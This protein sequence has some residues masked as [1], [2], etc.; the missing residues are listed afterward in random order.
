MHHDS[1]S[2]DGSFVPGI[3]GNAPKAEAAPLEAAVHQ[4]TVNS[5]F[6]G[7]R[8]EQDLRNAGIDT[9]AIVG[10][11]T[12]HCVSKTTRM[13][14]LGFQAYVVA[15]A[16]TTFDQTGIDGRRERLWMFTS[17]HSATERRVSTV[18][19]TKILLAPVLG[20]RSENTSFGLV[21]SHSVDRSWPPGPSG[22]GTANSR[23]EAFSFTYDYHSKYVRKLPVPACASGICLSSPD[24]RVHS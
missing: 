10:L 22:S 15:D 1:S 17:L 6:I 13:G 2:A 7:T 9:V 5:S 4:K 3:L 14:N 11:T 21:K 20:R 19:D 12:Q 18:I 16:T 8:L 23:L 24:P